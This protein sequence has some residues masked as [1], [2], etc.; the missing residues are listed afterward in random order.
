MNLSKSYQDLVSASNHRIMIL[1]GSCAEMLG[2]MNLAEGDFRGDVLVNHPADLNGCFDV[3]CLSAPDI[4]K[5]I[6]KSFL[7]AG[8]DFIRTNTFGTNYFLLQR[9]N[10]E[11]CAYD[12]S[13]ACAR[14]AREAIDEFNK[15]LISVGKIPMRKFAVGTVAQV[16]SDSATFMELVKAYGDVVAGLL[17]GG[18]DALFVESVADPVSCRACL[19]A[20]ETECE[21]RGELFPI[22]VSC[23][24][25]KDGRMPTGQ[26]LRAFWHC[27]SSYPLF[28]FGFEGTLS[29]A[30]MLPFLHDISDIHV[31]ISALPKLSFENA[32]TLQTE[33]KWVKDYGERGL[34]NVIGGGPGFTPEHILAVGR[35]IAGKKLRAIPSRTK[36]LLL[37][38]TEAL[39][40]SPTNHYFAVGNAQA[41]NKTHVLL[42][43]LDEAVA[44][45][46]SAAGHPVMI[47]SSNWDILVAGMEGI[48]GK[49]I[50]NFIS[51]KYGEESFLE[52]ASEIRK[53]G[54]AVVCKAFDEQGLA[55]T[56]ERRT[57]V[58][59]R[60]Y[61]LLIGKLNFP[62]E[63]ILFDLNVLAIGTG[64]EEYANSA[65]DFIETCKFVKSKLPF[66][67]ILA[68]VRN[69]GVT[70]KDD[71]LLSEKVESV[72]MSFANRA[73]MDFAIVGDEILPAYENISAE[74]R[75]LIENLIFNC[76]SDAV[77]RLK[78]RENK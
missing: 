67:H 78:A 73:G 62:P 44:S 77:E 53:R 6:H 64:E 1:D 3:L 63:D 61:C 8:S 15:G 12:I 68:D 24:I 48:A 36:S 38:G 25:D 60:M 14:V 56:Y 39:E 69:L 18:A 22:M 33:M 5:N 17:D 13:K 42:M 26:S 59:E 43:N 29:G 31:R 51:L 34:V 32:E 41:K 19:Y 46:S 55:T 57:Q 28:S 66:A 11:D 58:I 65:K 71:K 45:E 49:G 4:V 74:E 16:P 76:S 50:V 35:A 9:Y 52:Q 21:R 20:I 47:Y 30:E 23:T 54:F 27:V 72:F 40:V 10:L 37:S 2:R 70:F 75:E 7:E